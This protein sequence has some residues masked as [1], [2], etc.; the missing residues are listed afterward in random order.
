MK[1]QLKELF[2]L[3]GQ[4][5]DIDYSI[6]LSELEEYDSYNFATPVRICGKAENRAGVVTLRYSAEFT[7]NQVC[8]RCLK[9]FTQGFNYQFEHI[10]VRSTNTGSDE[11]VV[12]GDNILDMNGLAISDLLLQLPTKILCREDCK[13]LCPKCGKDLN[14]G[15]CECCQDQAVIVS[16][17]N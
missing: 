12:C 1:V 14:E 6:E 15:N 5:K 9:E 8:D 7:L 10:L 3:V 2:E 17:F 4:V 16:S 11:F 13:G